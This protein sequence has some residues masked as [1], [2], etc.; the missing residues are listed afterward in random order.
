MDESEK[1][2]LSAE[3][4]VHEAPND[5]ALYGRK[6][7]LWTPVSEVG[8][9]AG[10]A[11]ET[12]KVYSKKPLMLAN[13]RVVD[14]RKRGW[15]I[16]IPYLSS[17]DRQRAAQ[18]LIAPRTASGACLV[19][20]ALTWTKNDVAVELSTG[21]FAGKSEGLFGQF[22]DNSFIRAAVKYTF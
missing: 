20:P 4:T 7:K 5:G 14:R 3:D 19:M 13:T 1:Q 15:D 12:L 2:N 16:G 6:N 22:H 8:G 9:S 11:I 17:A 18:I 21:I 10:I